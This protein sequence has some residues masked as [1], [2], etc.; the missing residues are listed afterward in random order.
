MNLYYLVKRRK[1]RDSSEKASSEGL[2]L[3]RNIEKN[4]TQ[5]SESTW[6]ELWEGENIQVNT[7]LRKKAN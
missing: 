2:F 3:H 7:E 4:Q 6:P 5:L 1:G